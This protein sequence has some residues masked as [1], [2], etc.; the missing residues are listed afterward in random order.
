MIVLTISEYVAD[1]HPTYISVIDP[2]GVT[3]LPTFTAPILFF[4]SSV[5]LVDSTY[6]SDFELPVT[7]II[8]ELFVLNSHFFSLQ[9]L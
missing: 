5:R 9:V 4:S 7:D 3:H 1:V 2:D 8:V 6:E